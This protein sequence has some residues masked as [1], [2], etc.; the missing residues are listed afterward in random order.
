MIPGR[1]A[2]SPA[3]ECSQSRSQTLQTSFPCCVWSEV[4]TLTLFMTQLSIQ[5]GLGWLVLQQQ[6]LERMPGNTVSLAP[7]M[8]HVLSV[9]SIRRWGAWPRPPLGSGKEGLKDQWTNN[10]AGAN[11]LPWVNFQRPGLNEAL[12]NCWQRHT[13]LGLLNQETGEDTQEHMPK[14][15]PKKVTSSQRLYKVRKLSPWGYWTP[16]S[17]LL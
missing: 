8:C 4:L 15:R 2:E 6:L 11:V 13:S 14:S 9:L 7:A 10:I 16:K 5:L 3:R 1:V 17:E 12:L